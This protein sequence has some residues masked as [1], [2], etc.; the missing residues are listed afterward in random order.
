MEENMSMPAL[1]V[2]L[3]VTANAS[4]QQP[5]APPPR[6]PC[7]SATEITKLQTLARKLHPQVFAPTVARDSAVIGLVFD[8]SCRVVQHGANRRTAGDRTEDDVW[9]RI[10]PKLAPD[11]PRIASSGGADAVPSREVGHPMIRFVVLR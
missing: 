9:L 8:K 5:A 6:P 2:A 10:F 11:A 1:V 4:L 3:V 7:E